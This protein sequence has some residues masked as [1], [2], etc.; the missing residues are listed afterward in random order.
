[1]VDKRRISLI[2]ISCVLTILLFYGCQNQLKKTKRDPATAL[3]HE[4]ELNAEKHTELASLMFSDMAI[5]GDFYDN[6]KRVVVFFNQLADKVIYYQPNSDSVIKQFKLPVDKRERW[7]ISNFSVIGSDSL[8]Y[9]NCNDQKM[10]VLSGGK[11]VKEFDIP[12]PTKNE[13]NSIYTFSSIQGIRVNDWYGLLAYA[14]F[15]D[16]GSGVSDSLIQTQDLYSF[17]NLSSDELRVKSFPVKPFNSQSKQS[18]CYITFNDSLQRIDFYYSFSDTVKSYYLESGK[19]E[20]EVISET[21]H[22]THFKGI[23]Q[24][25]TSSKLIY[26]P[27]NNYYI[28]RI[29]KDTTLDNNVRANMVYIEI[30]N[31]QFEAIHEEYLF[32]NHSKTS[33]VLLSN[34][35]YFGRMAKK[36]KLWTY[37]KVLMP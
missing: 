3:Q 13:P 11:K 34:G 27:I 20:T 19:L 2:G 4:F 36:K 33:L 35:V 37:N 24:N 29:L 14:N 5:V 23:S 26:D 30:L 25:M 6:D 32:T 8:L 21:K 17:F 10:V 15:K 9:F 7:P 18:N 12:P 31:D 16:N 28:R 1:M 22:P